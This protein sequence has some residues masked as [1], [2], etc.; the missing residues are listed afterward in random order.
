M[1]RDRC[2]D[3]TTTGPRSA[4]SSGRADWAADLA[5]VEQRRL[6]RRG[7]RRR[8]H[9]MD[10]GP[11]GRRV[12][13][14]TAA[15]RRAGVPGDELRD[16]GRGSAPA[17]SWRL[18]RGGS[19]GDRNDTRDAGAVDLLRSRL[20]DHAARPADGPGHRRR[21]APPARPVARPRSPTSKECCNEPR[22]DERVAR[23]TR[24][25]WTTRDDLAAGGTPDRF[26]V[27]RRARGV[28]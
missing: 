7:D 21:P 23:R 28:A 12:V 6:P 9:G 27:G 10:V 8:H 17:T 5:D 2:R 26:A 13:R 11:I 18:H 24:R 25:K 3:R 4:T 16:A 15:S 1:D 22:I 19:P 14:D 20:R